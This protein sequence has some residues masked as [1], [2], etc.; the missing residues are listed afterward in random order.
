EETQAKLRSFLPAEASVANPVDMLGGATGESYQG[1]IPVLLADPRVDSLIILFV[2]PVV[3][4]AAEVAEAVARAVA[5]AEA[6]EKPV[7]AVIV[8]EGGI[9]A[10]LRGGSR[11]IAAF[12]YPES[13]AHALAA[14]ASRAEWLRRPAGTVP[15]LEGVDRRAAEGVV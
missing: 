15:Q 2:P 4:G 14:V 10:A 9:P 13:A 6:A 12:D 1:A 7:L 3:A 11:A 5:G 8:A